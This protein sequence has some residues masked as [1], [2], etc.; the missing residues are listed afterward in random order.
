MMLCSEALLRV[1]ALP[2]RDLV[3]LRPPRTL[4]CVLEAETATQ[5]MERLR[6]NLESILHSAVPNADPATRRILLQLARDIHN[7]RRRT[8][9]EPTRSHALAAIARDCERACLASWIEASAA[10]SSALATAETELSREIVGH[11]RARLY[12]LARRESFLR[13]VALASTALAKQLAEPAR[14]DSRPQSS[15]LERSLLSYLQRA[16]AKTSP[17]SMFMYSALCKLDASH[18]GETVAFDGAAGTNVTY[19]DRGAHVRIAEATLASGGWT[20]ST[21]LAFTPGL[22]LHEDGVVDVP[23]VQYVTIGRRLWRQHKAARFRLHPK[24]TARLRSLPPRFSGARL[25]EEIADC[26]LAIGAAAVMVNRLLGAQAVRAAPSVDA[27]TAEPGVNAGDPHGLDA[28]AA[29]VATANSAERQQLIA[30]AEAIWDAAWTNR[31]AAE[32]P[33]SLTLIHEDAHLGCEARL[34][35]RVLAALQELPGALSPYVV[36]QPAYTAAR[37]SFLAHFGEGGV[38]RD[39]HA[40]LRSLPNHASELQAQGPPHSTGDRAS[41]LAVCAFVQLSDTRAVGNDLLVVINQLHTG[42]GALSARYALGASGFHSRLATSLRDWIRAIHMPAEPLDMPLCGDINPLQAHPR[43]TDRVLVIDGEPLVDQRAAIPLDD[44]SLHHDAASN[45][46][47]FRDRSTGGVVTP[48]YMGA[49]RLG[50]AS[51]PVYWLTV[52]AQRYHIGHVSDG[53]VSAPDSDGGSVVHYPRQRSGCVVL[54]RARWWV[55]REKL[56]AWLT[57]RGAQR[58]FEFTRARRVHGLPRLVYARAVIDPSAIA[59]DPDAHKP[60]WVDTENPFFLELL[61]AFARRHSWICLTEALPEG[62]DSIVTVDGEHHAAEFVLEF[63][64]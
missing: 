35:G 36:E 42:G 22:A 16:G 21:V 4:A 29:A 9:A 48:V 43:L 49:T 59:D 18:P 61:E 45:Q 51:G 40:F 50:P 63:T 58:L 7:G 44:L 56:A 5:E 13:P 19:V 31:P 37:S 52:L 54:Q 25:L 15:K 46:L 39:L 23:Q 41:R 20:G 27:F 55:R 57:G 47:F 38:C 60:V 64:V 32:R 30:Q 2:Y 14:P 26:G 62:N 11:T 28:V 10:A 33:L 12:E 3:A 17:F 8:V 1:A 53:V 6:P 34:G 24:I